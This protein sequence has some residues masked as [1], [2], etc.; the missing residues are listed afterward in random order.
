MSVVTVV[1]GWPGLGAVESGADRSVYRAGSVDGLARET[2]RNFT[3]PQGYCGVSIDCLAQRQRSRHQAGNIARFPVLKVRM[4]ADLACGLPRSATPRRS[5]PVHVPL[6]R[7]D[8]V[9]LG[10]EVLG[11]RGEASRMPG[12]EMPLVFQGAED[13]GHPCTANAHS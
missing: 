6:V 13:S 7:A 4:E 2:R 10:S 12:E 8:R 9:V 1:C 11:S 3:R 5:E